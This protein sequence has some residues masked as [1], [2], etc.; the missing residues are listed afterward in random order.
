MRSLVCLFI[1][2]I[3]FSYAQNL[4]KV[5]TVNLINEASLISH[6]KILGSDEFLGRAP[7]HKGE[8]K[9]I[10]YLLNEYKKLGLVPVSG[11]DFIQKIN[12]VELTPSASP[13]INFS[14]KNGS[15]ELDYV[16]DYVA[17]TRREEA[18]IAVE[19]TEVI[20][21]GYG[22]V[23][24]EYNWNDFANIDVKNKIIIVMVNDPGY[25]TNNPKLFTGKA[26]TYYGRWVYKYEEAARQGAAGIFIIHETNAASY[27]WEVVKNGRVA[28]Q[29]FIEEPDKN[30]SR[31]KFEGWITFPKAKELFKLAGLN[32]EKELKNATLPGF[33][34]KSLGLTTSLQIENK[35][36]HVQTRNVLG[37]IPGS[38]RAD[39]Y[40]FYMAHW[41]HLGID[42]SL[43]GDQIFNGARDNATG[44]AAILQVADAFSKL[45][46]KP[47]RSIA[48]FSVA[49]EEQGLIGSEYYVHHP[50]IPLKKTVAVINFDGL[51]IFGRTKD[52]ALMGYGLSELDKYVKV[53]AASRG[54][55]VKPDPNPEMGGYFRSDHFNFAK[56]GVPSIYMRH[57]DISLTGNKDF[58]K[59]AADWNRQHYHKVTDEY[60]TSWNMSGMLE[61][62][63]MLFNVGWK[64]ANE[65]TFP[66]WNP[67]SKYFKIRERS[68]N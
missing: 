59:L 56:V 1:I 33:K 52:V 22:I 63:E 43:K 41:D 35:I 68:I 30:M 54:K 46:E 28:P 20:F 13:K 32:L 26:M 57:G 38:S 7:G 45:K 25:A 8:D 42:A 21:A 12:L 40:V 4:S 58:G 9:T 62:I 27:P 64:L 34:A 23:A 36:E 50:L 48:I 65:T 6:I 10:K 39:E 16:N 14:G 44:V 11:N 17:V 51:N 67:N 47:K 29:Y 3:T 53:E 18:K 24:P 55:I 37:I 66:K 5:E 31:C 61:E 15:V 19:P 2:T 49:G 60:N